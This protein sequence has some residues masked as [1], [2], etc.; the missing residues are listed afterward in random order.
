MFIVEKER[1]LDVICMG[2]VAVDLYAEQIH[3]SLAEAETFRKYLGGCAGNIAVGTARLGLKSAIFSCIGQDAMGVFLRS[4]LEKEKVDT[5]LLSE[6]NQHLTGLVLL[7]IDPP[8]HFPLMFYRKDCADMQLSPTDVNKHTIA[9]AKALLFTGTGISTSSMQAA[10]HAAILAAK[11]ARTKVIL[12]LDYRPVLWGLTHSGDGETRFVNAS[13]VT[14]AYQAFLPYCDLIVGTVEELSIASGKSHIADSI[15][16]LHKLVKA[17]IVVKT[18][19]EGCQIHFPDNST[20]IVAKPFVVDI[21][22]VLGAGDAFMSGLLRGLLRGEDWHTAAAYANA[23]GALVVTRHGC[24]PANPFWEELQFFIREFETNPLVWKDPEL[25]SLHN[26]L[27]QRIL[28]TQ[29]VA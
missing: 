18:G 16:H 9:K 2:R 27:S 8:F 25:T 1:P 10:T 26:E 4:T 6:T 12:D 21:L 14:S 22:N 15:S 11:E 20:P 5:S 23:C 28:Q 19:A 13:K 7:G 29:E 3:C 24:A 17:P